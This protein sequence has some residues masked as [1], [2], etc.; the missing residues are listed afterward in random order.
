MDWKKFGK[1]LIYPHVAVIWVLLSISVV[2]L[3]ISLVYLNSTSI[4]S[5]ISYLVAFYELLVI[6]F[7]IPSIIKYFKNIKNENKIINKIVSDI[8]L[9]MNLSLYGTLAF[10]VAF[11]L[12]QLALGIYNHS[13]W[14]YAMS[15]YYVVLAVIRFFILKH[16]RRFGLNEECVRELKLYILCGW[17]LLVLNLALAVI[18]F[19]MIYYHQ[20]FSH[21]EIITI[22]IAAYTFV[23]FTFSIVNSIRYRRFNS[24]TYSA[25][26]TISLVS[27]CVSMLTLETTML[28]TFGKEN[29][30]FN[31]IMMGCSGGVVMTFVLTMAIYMIVSGHK[32]LNAFVNHLV[33]FSNIHADKVDGIK[34]DDE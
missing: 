22:T 18:L 21:H 29:V 17:L 10:N 26:K 14:F 2:F 23:S 11:G 34:D 19:F 20:T 32:N 12:F 8:H 5:I 15:A 27:A 25:S 30:V 7:R 24:P 4:L 16:T 13:L 28:T 6:C 3:T 1:S 9:R 31:Q 33:D